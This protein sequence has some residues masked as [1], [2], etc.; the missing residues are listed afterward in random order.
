MQLVVEKRTAGL[1]PRKRRVASACRTVLCSHPLARPS[2]QRH[3]CLPSMRSASWKNGNAGA[4]HLVNA[5]R[6]RRLVKG[7][8]K[9]KTTTK[10]QIPLSLMGFLFFSQSCDA[11]SGPIMAPTQR[12]AQ[13]FPKR[14]KPQAAPGFCC[15]LDADCWGSGRC[16]RSCSQSAGCVRRSLAA[17]GQVTGP[18]SGNN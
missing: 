4:A 6:G 2:W 17:K 1:R 18:T 13:W 7:F 3:R 9:L 11:R 15:I 12:T 16:H 5:G 14:G 8:Y 10:I